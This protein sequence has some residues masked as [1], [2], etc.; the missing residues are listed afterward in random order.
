MGSMA[1]D[2]AGDIALGYSVSSSNV[3]PS[4]RYTGRLAGDPV[5]TLP[6]GE[7]TL[8]AG[9]GSQ[10]SSFNRWGDY[11]MMAVA[12][13]DDCTFWY[14][15]EYYALTS[16]AGWQTRVGS[17]TFPNC[18]QPWQASY[19]TAKTPTTWSTGQ[20]QTYQVTLTNTGNQVWPAAGSNPVHLGV[21]F[22]TKGGGTSVNYPWLTDQRFSLPNDLAAGVAVT[23]TLSVA[24][25]SSTTGN[26]VLEY[27]MVK[28]DLFW[29]SQFADLT[30]NVSLAWGASYTVTNTPTNWSTDQTQTYHVT[31]TN[32]GNQRWPAAGSNPVHLGVH[33]ATKGGGTSVNY[34]WLT[35]QRSPLPPHLA[36]GGGVTLTLTVPAPTTVTR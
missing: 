14:T 17:F 36:A 5:G 9:S 33:F 4:I 26:L 30:V 6:Q 19:G 20:T 24:S 12:P 7:A 18:S 22:A 34:P 13:T 3:S 11:S 2:Q 16:T 21:H 25:P 32:T 35:D 10:T 15:Q 27:Q 29:F 1:M 28:E 8:I 23:L 31:L